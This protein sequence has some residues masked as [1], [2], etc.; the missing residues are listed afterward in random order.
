MAPTLARASALLATGL[1]L[2]PLLASAPAAAGGVCVQVGV[3]EAPWNNWVI[4]TVC[5]SA[6]AMPGGC[7]GVSLVWW[8]VLGNPSKQTSQEIWIEHLP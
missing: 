2:A 4:V 5:Q 6:V 7:G 1:L 3:D 8:C